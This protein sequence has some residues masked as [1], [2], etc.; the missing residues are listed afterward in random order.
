MKAERPRGLPALS[1]QALARARYPGTNVHFKR[2]CYATVRRDFNA[3]LNLLTPKRIGPFRDGPWAMKR[4]GGMSSYTSYCQDQAADSARRARL[5]R[6]PELAAYWRS[7][8]LRWLRLAEHAQGTD[9]AL[10]D[11]TKGAEQASS[12]HP[13]NLDAPHAQGIN[14]ATAACRQDI[15]MKLYQEVHCFQ[16]QAHWSR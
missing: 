15:L 1:H 2:D 10:G 16:A 4:R 14:N 5:A 11:A 13:S 9:G 12:L 6:S 8:G 7:L 3:G